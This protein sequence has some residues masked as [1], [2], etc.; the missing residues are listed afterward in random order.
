MNAHN[1]IA[2]AIKPAVDDAILD[3]Q[4]VNGRQ[5]LGDRYRSPEEL[6]AAAA[7]EEAPIADEQ[8]DES[9]IDDGSRMV[10]PWRAEDKLAE[11][12]E[13]IANAET[14]HLRLQF[15]QR[16]TI[17]VLCLIDKHSEPEAYQQAI[18]DLQALCSRYEVPAKAVQ[19]LM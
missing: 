11:W 8:I 4:A 17:E 19:V 9:E 5:E 6:D 18:D 1:P 12:I 7:A 2:A 3:E 10:L 16:A 15:L 13:K 14:K